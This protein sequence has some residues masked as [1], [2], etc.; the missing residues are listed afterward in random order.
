ML[1]ILDIGTVPIS[2][3]FNV[4]TVPNLY[5]SIVR[6]VPMLC[7]LNI[8]TVATFSPSHGLEG[9]ISWCRVY[10]LMVKSVLSHG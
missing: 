9:N 6:T 5:I 1:C 10:Y 8:G 4:V 7:I 2:R 3:I